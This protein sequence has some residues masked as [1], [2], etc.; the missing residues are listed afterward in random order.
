MAISCALFIA[1]LPSLAN[2]LSVHGVLLELTVVDIHLA[3]LMVRL[4]G[5]SSNVFFGEARAG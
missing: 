5:G 3:T 1:F 4:L 2:T